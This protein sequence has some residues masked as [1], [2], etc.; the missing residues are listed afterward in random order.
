MKL[1]IATRNK[2]KLKELQEILGDD[3]NLD[4]FSLDSFP[5]VGEIEETGKTFRENA[6]LKASAVAS[7]TGCLALAD[8]SG[9]CVDFLNGSPGVF[10]A[11]FAGNE[12]DDK[13]NNEQL[14]S[15]L[16]GIALERR[17]GRFVCNIAVADSRGM[18][19]VVEGSIEGLIIDELRGSNGFGYDP[20]FFIPEHNKTFAEL[21]PEIKNR[22][23][24]RFQ[25]LGQ[26]KKLLSEHLQK[27]ERSAQ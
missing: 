17:T 20:L 25:A 15:L 9:L 8:D 21:G 11:R 27:T 10:S 16:D 5:E 1:V 19:D 4:I 6:I 2:K 12:A 23:S 3:L 18:I 24:H 22:I 26:A 13:A 7:L 14:L